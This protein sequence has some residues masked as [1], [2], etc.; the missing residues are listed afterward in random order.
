MLEIGWIELM[1]KIGLFEGLNCPLSCNP[2]EPPP[3]RPSHKGLIHAIGSKMP[4]KVRARARARE[5]LLTALEA[6]RSG[7]RDD[8]PQLWRHALNHI[9]RNHI[10]ITKALEQPANGHKS[11]IE[12]LVD[13]RDF[14]SMGCVAYALPRGRYAEGR[15]VHAGA[16]FGGAKGEAPHGAV[17]GTGARGFQGQCVDGRRDGLWTFEPSMSQGRLEIRYAKD[18][19]TEQATYV[20]TSRYDGTM[21]IDGPWAGTGKSALPR[22]ALCSWTGLRQHFYGSVDAVQDMTFAYLGIHF[23][24]ISRANGRMVQVDGSGLAFEGEFAAGQ[25]FSGGSLV[26]A[27][28]ALTLPVSE[29]PHRGSPDVVHGHVIGEWR[30]NKLVQGDGQFTLKDGTMYKGGLGANAMV[31]G[32]GA[33]FWSSGGQYEGAF[34][35][36]YI[37]GQGTLTWSDGQQLTGNFYRTP[38]WQR[39]SCGCSCDVSHGD[40]TGVRFSFDAQG[41]PNPFTLIRLGTS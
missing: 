4:G 23:G 24:L 34:D 26:N 29:K 11:V 25:A 27:R 18:S 37:Q 33:I 2:T 35:N 38:T 28:G 41:Q 30:E 40:G 32:Q 5:E 31:H 17:V 15:V 9:Q 13:A 39:D 3:E 10:S 14:K 7:R 6:S 16:W 20:S 12:A 22:N 1:P 21:R 19:S 8:A 36:G